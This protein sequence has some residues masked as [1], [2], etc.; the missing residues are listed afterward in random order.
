MA[1]PAPGG[2][3]KLDGGNEEADLSPSVCR[4][5]AFWSEHFPYSYCLTIAD[6]ATL[7]DRGGALEVAMLVA[8]NLVS[9]SVRL[10][11][12]RQPMAHGRRDVPR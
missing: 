12:L 2:R 11:S 7:A 10:L 5:D 4:L 9:T 1:V 3:P 6:N 8:A